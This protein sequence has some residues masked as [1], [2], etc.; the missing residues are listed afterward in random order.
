M[1]GARHNT[2]EKRGIDSRESS[3]DRQ[4]NIQLRFFVIDICFAF[5]SIQTELTL[6]QLAQSR[7]I[8]PVGFFQSLKKENN[9][10]EMCLFVFFRL[11]IGH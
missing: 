3:G 11:S 6:C 4:T 5:A 1:H 2:L 9:N 10:E 7:S 8:Q